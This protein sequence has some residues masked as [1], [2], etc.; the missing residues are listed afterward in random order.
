[1]H[2]PTEAQVLEGALVFFPPAV[3][4]LDEPVRVER[5]RL[6]P[7]RGQAARHR[8]AGEHDVPFGDH[9]LGAAVGRRLVGFHLDVDFGLAHEHD[10]WGVHPQAFLHAVVQKVHL[11]DVVVPEESKGKIEYV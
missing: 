8:W 10:E 2:A 5:V 4:L 3:F 6:G 11:G 7:H 9:P 1:V